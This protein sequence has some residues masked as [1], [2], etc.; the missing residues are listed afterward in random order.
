M[1]CVKGKTSTILARL[2][3][4]RI[5]T[6]AYAQAS[7]AQEPVLWERRIG[8]GRGA[9]RDT[10]AANGSV[11]GRRHRAALFPTT[12]MLIVGADRRRISA[13]DLAKLDAEVVSEV[14]D[15]LSAQASARR[16]TLSTNL[17]PRPPRV[18]GKRIELQQVILHLVMNA[19]D[20]AAAN[21]ADESL[22]SADGD[23]RDQVRARSRVA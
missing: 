16:V 13:T 20:A 22:Q 18:S 6:Y 23:G 2:R 9:V 8:A 1:P 21:I 3:A 4:A 15:L 7:P 11:S 12:P 17:A 5:G 14:F 19:M 10:P